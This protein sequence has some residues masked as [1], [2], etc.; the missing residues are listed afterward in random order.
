MSR[1]MGML[2][3]SDIYDSCCGQILFVFLLFVFCC[4]FCL[5]DVFIALS[6]IDDAIYRWQWQCK[7]KKILSEL[8]EIMLTKLTMLRKETK[9]RN[10]KQLKL[11]RLT[12]ERRGLKF[13]KT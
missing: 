2:R 5:F 3:S 6:F 9:S 10:L 7:A 11:Q 4:I 8:V 12:K 1:D 13:T